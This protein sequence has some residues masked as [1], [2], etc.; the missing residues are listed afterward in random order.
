MQRHNLNLNK[1]D[2]L[3]RE[4]SEMK[5][6]NILLSYPDGPRYDLV[7]NMVATAQLIPK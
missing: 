1:L 4:L 3:R 2:K 6:S 5:L 7:L